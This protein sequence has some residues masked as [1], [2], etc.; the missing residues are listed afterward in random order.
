MRQIAMMDENYL[1]D[2]FGIDAEL[3]IDHAWGRESTTIADIKAY[4]SKSKSLS[5]GQVLMRDYKCNEGE[6]IAKE[7][8]DQLCLDMT[9]KK[10]ATDSVSLYVGYSHTEGIPGTGGTANPGGNRQSLNTLFIWNRRRMNRRKRTK[11]LPTRESRK[12]GA[13]R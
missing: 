8:M 3:L 4:R 2:W 12:R 13:N 11:P 1:Y 10:L 7:M 5:S 9:A 6:I